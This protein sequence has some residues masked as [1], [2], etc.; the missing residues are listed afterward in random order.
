LVIER[1]DKEEKVLLQCGDTGIA[2]DLIEVDTDNRRIQNDRSP[3]KYFMRN[4]NINENLQ[5]LVSLHVLN[6]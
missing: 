6:N 3:V 4:V 2:F 5:S 1:Y